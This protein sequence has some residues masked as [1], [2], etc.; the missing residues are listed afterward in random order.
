MKRD[1]K[2]IHQEYLRE[3]SMARDRVI[4]GADGEAGWLI[5]FLQLNLGAL[6]PREWMVCAY[7]IAAFV[8]RDF[9]R[10]QSMPVVSATG[11]AMQVM[12]EET[13]EYTLPSRKEAEQLQRT[14]KKHLENLWNQGM[15]PLRF[16]DLTLI[17]TQPGAGT[18]RQG[19]ILVTTKP[20]RKEF[21]YRM[22]LVVA[23]YAGRIRMCQECERIFLA[24]RR[25]QFFCGPRCQTRVSSRKWRMENTKPGNK[26]PAHA[27]KL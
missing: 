27:K 17:V 2:A 13:H 1:R 25:D 9:A 4:A 18:E 11:W 23:Q 20:K 10:A 21:E 19:S 22:A 24:V 6:S 14:I 12:P 7:E 15:T 26:E 3:L 16:K 8:E 5:R